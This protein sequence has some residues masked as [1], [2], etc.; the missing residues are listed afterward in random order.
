MV[1]GPTALITKETYD[2]YRD[3]HHR[4]ICRVTPLRSRRPWAFFA[5]AGIAHGAPRWMV[6]EPGHPQSCVTDL[7]EVATRLRTHLAEDPPKRE[8][9]DLAVAALDRFLDR[10]T[11]EERNLLPRRMLR[12][13]DQMSA[14]LKAWAQKARLA[15]DE[16]GASE[17]LALETLASSPDP[18]VDPYLVA[19]R[20]LTL[21]GPTFEQHRRESRGRRYILLSDVQPRLIASPLTY[22]EVAQKFVELP[23]ATPLDERVTACI[24]GVPDP[25]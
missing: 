20:W 7:N 6:I 9:D 8:L 1:Y 16:N 14:V 23:Q 13:L 17:W 5:I 4:V 25:H 24:I 19:E 21:I 2:Y 15:G 10:A 22:D 12:A 18:K 3:D 11:R